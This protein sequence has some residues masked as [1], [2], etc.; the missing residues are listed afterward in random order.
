MRR[1]GVLDRGARHFRPRRC[2]MSARSA[3]AAELRSEGRFATGIYCGGGFMMI[4]RQVIERMIAAYPRPL[5]ERPC[6]FQRQGQTKITRC[7]IA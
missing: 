2:F 3:R 6:L 5:Q 1:C 4:K 7:S